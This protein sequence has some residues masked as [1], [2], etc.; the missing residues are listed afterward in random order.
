[1]STKREEQTKEREE[2]KRKLLKTIKIEEESLS[3]RSV[4][5]LEKIMIQGNLPSGF[6]CTK[7]FTT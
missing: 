1:M 7:G 5:S 6:K 3:I 2:K 4:L